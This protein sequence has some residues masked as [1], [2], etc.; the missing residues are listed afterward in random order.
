MKDRWRILRVE[1]VEKM[2]ATLAPVYFERIITGEGLALS[3]VQ[4]SFLVAYVVLT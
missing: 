2:S 3:E 4:R 1:I